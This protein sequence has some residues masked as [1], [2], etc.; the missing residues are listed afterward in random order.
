LTLVVG[1]VCAD[2]IVLMTDAKLTNILGVSIKPEYG[3]KLFGD[4]AHLPMG[5]T[6]SKEAFD[7]FRKYIVGDVVLNRNTSECYTMD[8]T[9]LKIARVVGVI[10]RRLGNSRIRDEFEL[11]IVERIQTFT[12]LTNMESSKNVNI[13]RL[14]AEPKQRTIFVAQFIVKEY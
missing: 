9:I 5:Y 13:N 3:R 10:N 12:I 11:N 2:G 1:A 8:N 7:F 14:E 4:L 6:G